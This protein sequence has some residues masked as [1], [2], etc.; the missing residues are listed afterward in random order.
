MNAAM[1][2]LTIFTTVVSGG[3]DVAVVVKAAQAA[4]HHF[5]HPAYTHVLKP[6][7]KAAAKAVKQ[8][9]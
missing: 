1:L 2:A 9:N 4:H 3:Q 5:V 6:V 8:S 7:G